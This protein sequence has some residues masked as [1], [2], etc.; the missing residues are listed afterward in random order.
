MR[1]RSILLMLGSVAMLSVLAGAGKA[2]TSGEITGLVTDPSG[3]A[4][5]GASVTVT[6]KATGATRRATTNSEGLYAFPSLLPG[7]YELKVEQAGFKTAQLG[8]VT[9]EVQQT[10]RRDIAMEIGTVGETVTVTSEGTLLNAEN[11]TVGTVIENRRIVDLPLN[12]RNFLQLVSTA[13]NV[14]FG[15][16][17]AGQSGSRQG[18]TRAQ[19]NIS[20]AGQRS[21]FNRFTID[22]VENTDVNFNTPVVLPSIDALQEFKVQTG[23][24]PA[25]FGRAATQINVSTKSGTRE[26]HG[27]LFE[28]LRNNALDAQI[29]DFTGTRPKGTKTQPFKWNQYGFTLDGPVWL[30]KKLFG[31]IGYDNRE[32][33]FFMTN[34]EGFRERRT[35]LGR[36]NLPP[37]AW[38]SGNF[39]QLANPIFD[40]LTRTQFAGNIIP[41]NRI[42]PTSL[43]LLEFYPAP[44]LN[45]NALGLN[46]EQPLGGLIDKDQLIARGDFIESSASNWA[47]RYSWGDEVQLSPGLKLNGTKLLTT[48]R[49]VMVSNTRTFGGNKVNEARFGYNSFFNSLGRE[50][51]NSRDVVAELN[52]P[53]VSLGPPISWGIPSIAISG[54][55]GFGDD[56]EGPYVNNNKTFQAVDNFSW[57]LGSH[58]VKFGGELRWDQ[59]NQIGNQF[60]RGAFLFEPNVTS[61]LGASGTG[62]SFADF[63]LGYCKRCEA[64]VSLATIEF[65]AFSQYFYIDDSWKIT[66]RLTLN[67]GLRYEYTPPWKDLTGRLVN[68]HVPFADNTP[69]VQDLSRHPTFIRMGSGDFYEGLAL[70]F[71]PA[72]KVARDGRLGERLIQS[73]RNDIAPRFGLAWSPTNRWTVRLGG[74]VFYTQD[75][76]NPRF[77]MARNLAGRRRDEATPSDRDLNWNT[78]FRNLGG[79]VRIDN[80]YVL[81]NIFGRRTPY[82]MQYMLNVQRQLANNLLFEIGYLGSLGR[83]LESLRA[84]NESIAGATGSVLSRAP[85]P[86][87]GRIQEVD[88]SGKSSYNGLSLKLEKR[89]SSG[90]TFLSGYTWSRSIDNASAIRSHDFDTLF[91]QNSYNLAAEKGLSSFHTAHR[92]VT[93]G[94]YQLP[95][96]KGRRWLDMGGVANAVLGGWELGSLIAIQTGFPITIA[97]GTDRSNTGAGFDRPNLIGV[98]NFEGDQR[99]TDKWFNTA[100]FQLQPLGTH[101]AA[102]RNIVIGPGLI[103]W[104]ASLLK[105]FNFTERTHLQFR[106]EAFNAAN[107]PNWGNPNNNFSSSSFGRITGTRGT[108]REL[109]FGLKLYF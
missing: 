30:P 50:L 42:H 48:V 37:T 31:P 69:N 18:G 67:L 53:G 65:R 20:V 17:N 21:Y 27:V 81:G 4:V 56:S 14:S 32:R 34:F 78:P 101:G 108:M 94:L 98:A 74:G 25:E 102:G 92:F 6:N 45:P 109:Q 93:S 79:T 43:K 39:S 41:Q 83:K 104:D 95:F 24:Y 13:P 80:P 90:F 55:T 84:F 100:A 29:Y 107:H 103:Q 33:A 86:E 15:F 1:M 73:D 96:G 9:L 28:F 54:F 64:S 11:A 88:G 36:Y 58:T 85:Y 106:F 40:P 105:N 97:A 44:T 26:Y 22:G 82:V 59:Y 8:N 91:P 61:N 57:T 72:I 71:N 76:G 19:Q 16:S 12:G 66:P 10:A 51:A 2:Q 87:F 3:A 52:I 23:I 35:G 77:D 7:V 75:T 47:G 70:R 68:I 38:R 60:A 5:S 63:L 89:F 62:N 49:Q 99:T 46:H